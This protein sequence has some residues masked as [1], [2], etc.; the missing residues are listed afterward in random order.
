MTKQT[1]CL[2][3]IYKVIVSYY[4]PFHKTRRKQVAR[5]MPNNNPLSDGLIK[6][7]AVDSVRDKNQ[8]AKN[9]QAVIL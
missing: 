2:I 7:M 5:V 4:C 6:S 1:E 3:K 8:F 9:F